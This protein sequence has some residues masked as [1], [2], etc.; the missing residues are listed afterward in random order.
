MLLDAA[1]HMAIHDPAMRIILLPDSPDPALL[2]ALP[3]VQKLME[4]KAARELVALFPRT[5]VVDAVRDALD[6]LRRAVLAGDAV[7]EGL[8][9][10]SLARSLLETGARCWSRPA[11]AI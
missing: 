11:T 5:A 3:Q 7:F 9:A 8:C 2:R 10:D 4:T 1:I 6:A